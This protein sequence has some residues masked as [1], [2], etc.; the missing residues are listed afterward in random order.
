MSV[1]LAEQRLLSIAHSKAN[2]GVG[3]F[4]QLSM[5]EI[6]QLVKSGA[7]NGHRVRMRHLLNISRCLSCVATLSIL[8]GSELR[9]L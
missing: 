2:F 9:R 7:E 4:G 1:H 6:F 5:F 3:V 8:H